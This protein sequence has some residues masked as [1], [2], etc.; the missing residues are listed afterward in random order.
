MNKQ[1]ISV[2]VFI[3]VVCNASFAQV[4]IGT[5][6]PHASSQLDVTS[7]SKG[8]LIPRMTTA[9]RMGIAS[10]ATGLQVFDTD[11]KSV[12]FYNGTAW[13]QL[14]I[15]SN[16]WN[17]TGNAATNPSTNF[18][19][20]TDNQPLRFRVNNMWA[21][22][23]QPT[24][25]NVFFGLGSGQSNTIGSNNT[26]NGHLVLYSNT[27]GSNNTASGIRALYSNTTG[28]N[29][30]G[31]GAF[32]LFYNTTGSSNTANGYYALVSN[33]TGNNNTAMGVDV[34]NGNTTA[35]QN[36]GIGNSAL[37]TQSFS[38]GGTAWISGNTAVGYAA[39]YANQPTST[40]DGINNTA[41]G[42]LAL[43]A[44]TAGYDNTGIGVTALYSNITGYENTATGR[45]S[46][47]FNTTG[48]DNTATGYKALRSNIAGVQNSANGVYALYSNS[49][50]VYNTANGAYALY[51]NTIGSAN[52][53][54]G[55]YANVSTGDL[56]NTTSIGFNAIADASNKV[57]VGNIDVTSIGG[58]V[59]WTSFSDG[60]YKKNIKEN[61]QGLSFITSL[62]PITYTVD[63]NGLN[64]HYDKGRKYDSA[65]EKAK[66]AMKTS[67]DE[68]AK[69][70]YNGFIAQDVEKAAQSIGYNFSGVDKP[71]TKDGL[72]GLRYADFVVPLVKAV[73]EQQTIIEDLK[74]QVE[75]AKAEIPMQI[76]KQQLIIE[77]LKKQMAEMKREMEL[78]KNKN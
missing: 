20:T 35:S 51:S 41:V 65:Y 43:T 62:R 75:A 63:I 54:L 34:L 31:N 19:G 76:G 14:S 38:N 13:S 42:N 23:I 66:V 58:Q 16:G 55:S 52:T 46:L 24:N 6:T 57:R 59:G 25:A 18:I 7:T 72:Y 1:F 2:V 47:F 11:T 53:A 56:T 45:Q 60:R 74:K 71:P 67:A 3:L 27:T 40:S 12:W 77:E 5:T 64:K 4:G 32:T 37:F 70:V 61:V 10:P 22:E 48:S 9:Q 44:N 8:L 49:S 30:T 33:T 78:L 15:G 26:A 29:N 21:G 69:I 28:N 68:A 73:Q 39:L 36:T 17:L 50:G